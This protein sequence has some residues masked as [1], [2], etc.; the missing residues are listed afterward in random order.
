MTSLDVVLPPSA[1]EGVDAG[2][3]GLV[4][5]WLVAEGAA[6][7][8]GEPLVRVVL[9]KTSIDVEAVVSGRL[10]KILVAPGANF[11]KGEAL[12]RIALA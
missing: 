7:E 12:G 5:A 9:V 11:A 2:V 4:D 8:A 6:V 10:E 3:Q 1:W